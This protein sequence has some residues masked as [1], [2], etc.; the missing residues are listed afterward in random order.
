MINQQSS[1]FGCFERSVHHDECHKA[2]GIRITPGVPVAELHDGIPRF[3]DNVNI[4]QIEDALAFKQDAVVHGPGTMGG[5]TEGV[6]LPGIPCRQDPFW[7][8][9]AP[10]LPGLCPG[11][12]PVAAPAI[13]QCAN[14]RH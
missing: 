11:H 14:A 9:E 3:H 6:C 4:V 10:P 8:D 5:G 1:I 7:G 12:S 2:V 13:G